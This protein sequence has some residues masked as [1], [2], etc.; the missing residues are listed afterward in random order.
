MG[1]P[2]CKANILNVSFLQNELFEIRTW[3]GIYS[4]CRRYKMIYRNKLKFAA[5]CPAGTWRQTDVGLTPIR[6]HDD[7]LTSVR[8]Q[9]DVRCVLA[10]LPRSCSYR[11]LPVRG[12]R[13]NFCLQC[14]LKPFCSLWIVWSGSTLFAIILFCVVQLSKCRTE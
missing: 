6:R 13:R 5:N 8:R 7:D 4:C 1:W 2:F 12:Q 3:K 11:L 10:K 14:I 9:Y